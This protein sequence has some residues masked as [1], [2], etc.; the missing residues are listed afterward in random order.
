MTDMRGPYRTGAL[1]VGISAVLHLIAPVFGGFGTDALT[2]FV[3][4]IVY[5]AIAYGLLQGYRW[6]AYLTFLLMMAG[7]VVAITGIWGLGPVPGWIYAGIVIA[8]WLAV[9]AL[10]AALWRSRPSVAA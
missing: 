2:L 5:M 8:D 6:L 1:F 10:F 7:S 3:V 4:G 9:L